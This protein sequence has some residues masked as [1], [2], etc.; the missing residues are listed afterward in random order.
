VSQSTGVDRRGLEP[1]TSS[2]QVRRST[3]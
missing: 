1:P 3:R 2:V